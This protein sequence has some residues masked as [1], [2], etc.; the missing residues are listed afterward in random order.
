MRVLV[1]KVDWSANPAEERVVRKR[2][3]ESPVLPPNNVVIVERISAIRDAGFQGVHPDRQQQVVA[4]AANVCITAAGVPR[5]RFTPTGHCKLSVDGNFN[6][7]VRLLVPFF[8][9]GVGPDLPS[10][11]TLINAAQMLDPT[12]LLELLSLAAVQEEEQIVRAVELH[13]LFCGANSNRHVPNISCHYNE[14]LECAKVSINEVACYRQNRAS[15]R[16][17]RTMMGVSAH[18]ISVLELTINEVGEAS[19]ASMALVP[20]S[21]T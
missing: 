3:C 4:A 11:S 10:F 21:G 8:D 2:H 12:L 17:K 13:K 1:L 5:N 16:T 20:V 7:A 18:P 19:E 15:Y 9:D 14:S 6:V